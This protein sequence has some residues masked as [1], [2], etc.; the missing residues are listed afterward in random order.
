[1]SIEKPQA[2]VESGVSTIE[3]PVSDEDAG[4]ERASF[5][6]PDSATDGEAA[7]LAACLGAYLRDRQVQASTASTGDSAGT[8]SWTLA[9]RYECRNRDDLPRVKSGEEWKMSGRTRGL[10]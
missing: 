3:L 1:M 2:V 6:V 8:D 9:G 10:R 5:T 7:A 4:D